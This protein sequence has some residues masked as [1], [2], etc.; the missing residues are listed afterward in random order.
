MSEELLPSDAALSDLRRALSSAYEAAFP[1][2][3]A[4]TPR[5][6]IGAL[7]MEIGRLRQEYDYWRVQAQDTL[8]D[9]HE[10]ERERDQAWEQAGSDR[11]DLNTALVELEAA[12]AVVAHARRGFGTSA[13]VGQAKA[14]DPVRLCHLIERYD[15]AMKARAE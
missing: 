6:A 2:Q 12:R 15:E 10:A 11:A 1:G 13:D 14:F 7:V 8:V 4:A 3:V 5:A 9:L